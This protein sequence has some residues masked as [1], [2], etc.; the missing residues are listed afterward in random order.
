MIA[1]KG[2]TVQSTVLTKTC[3]SLMSCSTIHDLSVLHAWECD[4]MTWNV[5][6][7]LASK[8]RSN[9]LFDVIGQSD[10]LSFYGTE[11]KYVLRHRGLPGTKKTRS[12]SVYAVVPKVL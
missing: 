6:K 10:M 4:P 11:K 5:V 8:N 2:A 3:T 1:D 7:R 12:R 9:S